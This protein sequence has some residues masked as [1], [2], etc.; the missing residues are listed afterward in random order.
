VRQRPLEELINTREHALPLIQEWVAQ[1]VRP[2]DV[3]P[4]SPDRDEVLLRTQITTRSPLGAIAH[5][6]G[7]IVI[8]CG[9]LRVLGSGHERLTRT[10]PDW[11]E[12][13]S[14]GFYLV[15]DDAVGGFFAI[16][17]GA[18]GPVTHKMFYFAPDSL[19]WEPTEM[20]FSAFFL[21]A[22]TGALDRFYEDIRWPGWEND[23]A[24]LHGDRCYFFAPPLF[25]QEGHGGSRRRFEVPVSESWGV[26]MEFRDQ[27]GDSSTA[28]P[29]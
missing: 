21:W 29:R 25:T 12:G 4:P 9:W 2:V 17:G 20:S 11:N 15:G 13:R 5:G 16:N 26:Q 23:V 24:T 18:L 1:A 10:L 28:D 22:C 8:D 3:L 14:D 27:L 7:G 19:D 6:T